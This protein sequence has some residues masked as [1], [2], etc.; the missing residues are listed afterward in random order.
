MIPIQSPWGYI[1]TMK[2]AAVSM[3]LS[4]CVQQHL[5]IVQR[6]YLKHFREEQFYVRAIL[7]IQLNT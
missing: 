1:M 4:L 3:T 5:H 7:M 2:I 6:M